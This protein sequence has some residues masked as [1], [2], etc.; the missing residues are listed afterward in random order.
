MMVT[1]RVVAAFSP[2]EPPLHAEFTDPAWTDARTVAIDRQWNGDAAPP[3]LVTTA[4]V[5]WTVSHLWVGFDCTYDDLDIDHEVNTGIER[6]ALWDRDVCEA[7]VQAP[8][9][10]HSASYKE[11]E[12]APTG[13]WCDLAIHRPRVDI[14]W[15][16]NGGMA[17]AGAIDTA[18]RRFRAVMRVPFRAF[19]VTPSVGDSWRVNLFRIARVGGVRHYLAHAPTG[20]STPDFHVPASFVPLEFTGT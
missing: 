18:T 7:F 16:W 2:L 8:T 15:T 11:F 17:T 10:P 1:M 4:R 13:Q 19:G 6:A 9:E 20:T 14:D 5:L 12:V 3:V